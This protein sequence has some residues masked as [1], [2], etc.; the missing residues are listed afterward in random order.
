MKNLILTFFFLLPISTFVRAQAAH[1]YTNLPIDSRL[2][3]VYDSL[4]LTNVKAGNPFLIQRMNF[5]LDNSW[6]LTTLP[7]QKM[8]PNMPAIQ[9][10]D[11]DNINIMA[12]EKERQIV[13]DWDQIKVYRIENRE[14]VLV[15]RS[16]QEC[17]E[18]LNEHL[19]RQ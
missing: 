7:A 17:A 9:I 5:Y 13:R 14:R 6:Y 18:L 1:T 4:Y 11:L 3:Q 16:G 2:Y 15:L 10:K 8:A 12:L 19:K